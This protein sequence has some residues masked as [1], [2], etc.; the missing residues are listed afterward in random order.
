MSENQQAAA[1]AAAGLAE[2]VADV[3]DAVGFPDTAAVPPP[4]SEWQCGTSEW[5]VDP[6]LLQQFFG[7]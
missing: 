3:D 7:G 5:P 4:S 6:Q 2:S 1:L